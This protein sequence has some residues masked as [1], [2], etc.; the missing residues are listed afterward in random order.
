MH[1]EHVFESK[2]PLFL[3]YFPTSDLQ[4]IYH[5]FHG[6][7]L[8]GS[9][10]KYSFVPLRGKKRLHSGI[11][12]LLPCVFREEEDVT[13]SLVL[14]SKYAHLS[15]KNFSPFKCGEMLYL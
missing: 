12:L 7:H 11:T 8:V 3:E 10:D 14:F 6:N 1:W 15:L 2:Y 4:G 9:S 5:L 13:V